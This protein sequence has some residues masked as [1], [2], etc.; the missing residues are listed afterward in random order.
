[1]IENC[2]RAR[3][4]GAGDSRSGA[5]RP[6]RRRCRSGSTRIPRSASPSATSTTVWRWC[7]RSIRRSWTSAASRWCSATRSWFAAC[8]LPAV[9]SRT[10]D[11]RGLRVFSGAAAAERSAERDRREPR[12]GGGASRRAADHPRARP[13]DQRRD[14]ALEASRSGAA[15]DPGDRR[16]RP[17]AG[18]AI[19]DRH[20]QSGRPSRLQLRARSA[21]RFRCCSTRRSSSCSRRSRSPRRSGSTAPISIAW[22][23]RHRPAARALVAPARAWQPLWTRLFGV[24]RLQSV[25]HARRRLCDF[26]RRVRL[27][28]AARPESRRWLTM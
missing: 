23:H 19:H 7:R 21:R 25:R 1:M 20:D 12:A 2:R 15:R 28:D 22:R 14:G 16:R 8:R 10:S 17:P 26:F 24:R 5:S 11:R 4:A 3:R 18:P 6:R 13:G 9:W 27:R